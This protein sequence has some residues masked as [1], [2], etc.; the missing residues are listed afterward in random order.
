[1]NAFVTRLKN[2][3]QKFYLSILAALATGTLLGMLFDPFNE[4]GALWIA[5]VPLCLIIR[6]S[7]PRTAFFTGWLAGLVAWTIQLHWLSRLA[8]TG[9]YPPVVYIGSLFLILYLGL[10]IGLF[11][12]LAALLRQKLLTQPV[13]TYWK[14]ILLVVIL[15]PALWVALETIRSH[16]FT[17]FA[18]NPLGLAFTMNLPVFQLAAVGGVS[19]VSALIV[20]LNGGVTTLIE[21]FWW[22]I[23]KKLPND[24]LT[25]L[26][27]SLETCMPFL[28]FLITF[29]WGAQR[30]KTYDELITKEGAPFNVLLQTT[31]HPA[32][33]DQNARIEDLETFK[34][35]VK[36]LELLTP[37]LDSS[38]NLWLMPESSFTACDLS[39]ITK[40]STKQKSIFQDAAERLSCPILIGGTYTLQENGVKKY[41]NASTLITAGNFDPTKHLYRKRHLVPFGEYIPFDKTFTSLQALVPTGV[42]CSAGDEKIITMPTEHHFGPLICFDDCDAT[43]S[44]D[45]VNAGAQFLV[46]SSNDAWFIPS[47]EPIAHL[48]QAIARCV[49]TGVPMVRTSNCG[50]ASYVDAVGRIY[51]T[52]QVTLKNYSQAPV[53]IEM[54]CGD[55]QQ[56]T[57]I[58]NIK[59]PLTQKPFASF[60]LTWGNLLLNLPCM[61]FTFGFIFWCIY[62][63]Y[64]LK[65]NSKTLAPLILLTC[66]LLPARGFATQSPQDLV[67][68]N[69]LPSAAMAIDDGNIKTATDIAN[70]ILAEEHI[71]PERRAQ[72][73]EILIRVDLYKEAFDDVI[74]RVNRCPDMT[75]ERS[76]VFLMLAYIGKKDYALI[77]KLYNSTTINPSSEWGLAATRLALIADL[78][79]GNKLRAAERFATVH[80]Q[81]QTNP[82]VRSANALAW[83]Q[84]FPSPNARDALLE[85]AK[86]ANLGGYP[87]EC[88]LQLPSA[89]KTAPS[90]RPLEVVKQALAKKIDSPETKSQLSLVA[91]QLATDFNERI[92]FAKVA[93]KTESTNLKRQAYLVLGDTYLTNPTPQEDGLNYLKQAIA[94]DIAAKDSPY[95][96]LRLAETYL[97]RGNIDLA[98]KE[99]NIY[100]QSFIIPELTVR[101]LQGYGRALLQKNDPI[102]A[103]SAFTQAAQMLTDKE[104]ATK[105]NELLYEAANAATIAKRFDTAIDLHQQRLALDF[106]DNPA[107]LLA[108]ANLYEHKDAFEKAKETY[109]K[110]CE[111]P[112]VSLETFRVATLRLG[113][114]YVNSGHPREAVECYSKAIAALP[115]GDLKDELLLARGKA[116]YSIPLYQEAYNDFYALNN[117][118]HQ[119]TINEAHFFI[120]LCLY[121][122]GREK[123]AHSIAYQYIKTSP[124]NHRIPDLLLWLAKSDFNNGNYV[125]AMT[126]FNTFIE[127]W[128]TDP[129]VPQILYLKALSSYFSQRYHDTLQSIV[130]LI[131]DYPQSPIVPDARFLQAKALIQHARHAEAREILQTLLVDHPNMTWIGEAY[132]LYGD[133]LYTTS[134][135]DPSRV[136]KAIQSYNS[137]VARLDDVDPDTALSYRFKIGRAYE[138]Q[139]HRPEA[140]TVYYRIIYMIIEAPDNY[141]GNGK[142]WGKRALVQLN[143]IE[144]AAGHIKELNALKARLKQAKIPGFNP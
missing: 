44:R 12:Y 128:G 18:W 41:Y 27:L 90:P 121:H 3:N 51:L 135:D 48:R 82:S 126:G 2:I 52:N 4:F 79:L 50:G 101:Y 124:N 49:E 131:K 80:K 83:N 35:N 136:E 102:D 144:R 139:N 71:S 36:Y 29:L 13:G 94:L 113:A 56:Q 37:F 75:S 61:L 86:D 106:K 38:F 97:A 67:A 125:A 32:L 31:E 26:Q 64:R 40:H 115:E 100:R 93:L 58:F 25:R 65:I 42:S 8:E 23:R 68:Q 47:I 28:L 140:A 62:K 70:R 96:Q 98:L 1:M 20:M 30:I 6:T 111:W 133:C 141:T 109:I 11:A 33:A 54:L 5:L 92:A 21:R 69:L 22:S 46:N 59:I 120:V 66:F 39:Q 19:M 10:Y 7:S 72:A 45:S 91:A 107:I 55:A 129:R 122:L 89:F 142:L 119:E 143:N 63:W 77:E 112:E 16:L 99:Y 74:A 15:E 116:Y 53:K 57:K 85:V 95:I 17:G 104:D 132:G 14:R 73:E 24:F 123:E 103:C 110:I 88:A 81:T 127:R 137:A 9:G 43:L 108:I 78:E 34:E 60:Y 84:A 118:P 130:R 87:L 134:S 117:A 114:I 138:K 105:K 76:L